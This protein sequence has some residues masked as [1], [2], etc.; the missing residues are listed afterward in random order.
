MSSSSSAIIANSH[1]EAQ[2]NME[3]D[4]PQHKPLAEKMQL[5]V[6]VFEI[7]RLLEAANTSLV[8]YR[9]LAE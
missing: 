1:G 5:D 6:S 4:D 9:H 8:V 3:E 7:V 2:V